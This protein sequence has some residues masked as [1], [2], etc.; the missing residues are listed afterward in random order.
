M[1]Q[2]FFEKYDVVAETIT[3]RKLCVRLPCGATTGVAYE[4]MDGEPEVRYMIFDK[5]WVGNGMS[6]H[7]EENLFKTMITTAVSLDLY[8]KNWQAIESTFPQLFIPDKI[9]T[10]E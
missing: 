9:K 7:G 10:R 8:I 2:E 6:I 4:E 1:K 5:R 3:R